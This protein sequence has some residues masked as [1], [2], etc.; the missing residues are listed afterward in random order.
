MD[1]EGVG[2]A[3]IYQLVNAGL[4]HDAADLYALTASQLEA[5]ERMGKKSAANLIAEIERSRGNEVWRLIYGLGIRHVGER[6]AQV[7]ARHLGSLEAIAAQS[8]E[9]LQ[10]VPEVGPVLAQAIVEWFSDDA[11]RARLYSDIGSMDIAQSKRGQAVCAQDR[12]VPRDGSGSASG[13]L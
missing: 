11:K 10:T 5:L 6:V 2:E 1:M 3:L 12:L 7:L 9:A 4:V 8:P 13:R